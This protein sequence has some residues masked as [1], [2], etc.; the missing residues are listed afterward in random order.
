MPWRLAYHNLR[1]V[2]VSG[3]DMDFKWS[4]SPLAPQPASADAAADAA[5]GSSHY[6]ILLAKMARLPASITDAALHIARHLDTQQAARQQQQEGDG[7]MQRLRQVRRLQKHPA[8]PSICTPTRTGICRSLLVCCCR[9]G[10]ACVL[11]RGCWWLCRC[12]HWFTSWG[13]WLV[14]QPVKGS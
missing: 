8:D 2:A 7:N 5:V 4:I 12:T 10:C 1:Q 9:Q 13:V 6:G 14:G 11:L 3:S